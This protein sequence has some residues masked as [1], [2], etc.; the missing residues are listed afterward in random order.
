MGVSG[1]PG[2][3][4]SSDSVF[5][6]A[7]P[8]PRHLPSPAS[9]THRVLRADWPQ[10][11][12]CWAPKAPG[13]ESRP[14][15][16]AGGRPSHCSPGFSSPGSWG[17]FPRDVCPRVLT[18]RRNWHFPQAGAGLWDPPHGRTAWTVPS[19]RLAERCSPRDSSSLREGQAAHGPLGPS[20]LGWVPAPSTHSGGSSSCTSQGVALRWGVLT[21]CSLCCRL[22]A[23]PILDSAPFCCPASR[24]PPPLF[25]AVSLS[26]GS[27]GV[28]SP[29]WD[30]AAVTCSQAALSAK[31]PGPCWVSLCPG[32]H[33]APGTRP[34]ES[35]RLAPSLTLRPWELCDFESCSA[36][37]GFFPFPVKWRR[38]CPGVGGRIA[39]EEQKTRL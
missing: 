1:A 21:F 17:P 15:C 23:R 35:E 20:S 9:V 14:R 28:T 3:G 27:S 4:G 5:A 33:G 7:S 31:G 6:G 24:A 30:P 18:E 8:P 34:S 39:R 37:L 11:D 25:W 2:G 22:R 19:L 16:P 26:P 29:T 38:T 10:G 13:P 12:A 36:S 32:A